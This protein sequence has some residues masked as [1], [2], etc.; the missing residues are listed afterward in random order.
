MPTQVKSRLGL[1]SA[2]RECS[3]EVQRYFEHIP[4]LLDEFPMEVC[5]AYV[6]SRLE[7]GQ[8]LALYCGIVRNHRVNSELA[9]K[10]V[11]KQYM[12]RDTF[13]TFYKTVF[14]FDLPKAAHEDLKEAAKIRDRAM[15]GKDTTDDQHRNAIAHVLKYAEEV[16][17]Q[18][19]GNSHPKPF[20][21]NLKGF[22]GNLKKL[23]RSTSR[24]VLMGMGF[25]KS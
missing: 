6:F 9:W 3:P 18:L 11:E 19:H 4:K 2:Y 16:N 5:L 12:T 15:H 1:K 23:E 10:A 22:A 17:K 25:F 13:V 8:N 20:G 21:G 24:F 14:D 7:L